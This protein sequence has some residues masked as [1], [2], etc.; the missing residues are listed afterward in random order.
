MLEN[1][2]YTQIVVKPEV[3]L[4]CMVAINGMAGGSLTSSWRTMILARA[5]DNS[6]RYI[7]NWWM[8]LVVTIHQY[9]WRVSGG[10]AQALLRSG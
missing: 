10:A 1:K 9:A 2:H 4:G 8:A 7:D 5:R 6:N 3:L